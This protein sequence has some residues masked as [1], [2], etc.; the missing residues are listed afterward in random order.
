MILQR[1][2]QIP[3]FQIPCLGFMPSGHNNL[4]RKCLD[5]LC[6]RENVLEI[7]HDAWKCK[8]FLRDSILKRGIGDP[9]CLHES[10]Q[11]QTDF[12]TPQCNVGEAV[13][14]TLEYIS[15]RKP[16]IMF[17]GPGCS[18]AAMPV[19]EAIHYWNV[20]QVSLMKLSLRRLKVLKLLANY[21]FLLENI[22]KCFIHIPIQT[23]FKL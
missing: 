18:K 12:L 21:N 15:S 20:V 5:F 17:L 13:R 4:N 2:N 3:V 1:R 14:R 9:L 11:L 8:I 23:G 22:H 16:K 6:E 19:A 10:N 7:I